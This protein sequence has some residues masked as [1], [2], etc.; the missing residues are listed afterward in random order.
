M[1]E[2][3]RRAL[4][5]SLTIALEGE[6]LRR[7]GLVVVNPPFVFEKEAEKILLFLT[8]LLAQGPGAGFEIERLTGE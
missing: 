2:S 5:L 8:P 7:T 4:R 1:R 6:G 3:V